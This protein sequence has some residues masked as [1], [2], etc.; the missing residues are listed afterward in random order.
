VHP[1]SNLTDFIDWLDTQLEYQHDASRGGDVWPRKS[2]ADRFDEFAQARRAVNE[3]LVT[4]AGAKS[5][6]A[7][8]PAM[9]LHPHKNWRN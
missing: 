5:A 8:V 2:A 4:R 6:E 9:R 3:Y 1:E 7:S